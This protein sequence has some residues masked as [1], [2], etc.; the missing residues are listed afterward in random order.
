MQATTRWKLALF[1]RRTGRGMGESH[2]GWNKTAP[3]VFKGQ[4]GENHCLQPNVPEGTA[5]RIFLHICEGSPGVAFA[6]RARCC[7]L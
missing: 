4:C 7:I 1:R 6:R 3:N 5:L 2:H